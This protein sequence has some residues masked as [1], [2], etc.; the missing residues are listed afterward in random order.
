[1]NYSYKYLLLF[2]LLLHSYTIG[3]HGFSLG[4]LNLPYLLYSS[5]FYPTH[6]STPSV[7]PKHRV[8]KDP[9]RND[10]SRYDLSRYDA[11]MDSNITRGLTGFLIFPANHQTRKTSQTGCTGI[12]PVRDWVLFV[13]IYAKLLSTRSEVGLSLEERSLCAL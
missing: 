13:N 1:M 11:S 2:D 5:L 3:A 6:C 7:Q 9:R 12:K 10:L 8:V 4:N